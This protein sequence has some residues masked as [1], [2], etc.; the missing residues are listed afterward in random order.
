MLQTTNL[1]NTYIPWNAL[2]FVYIGRKYKG[3]RNYF[4]G[5]LQQCFLF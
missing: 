1:E 3:Q 2:S 5:Y 4:H